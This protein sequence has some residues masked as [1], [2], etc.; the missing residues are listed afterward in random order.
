MVRH[1][2]PST[3]NRTR[4]ADLDSA[5]RRLVCAL[6]LPSNVRGANLSSEIVVASFLRG[7]VWPTWTRAP[8]L[9]WRGFGMSPP[10]V[11]FLSPGLE[12]SPHRHAES[13]TRQRNSRRLQPPPNGTRRRRQDRRR[14]GPRL[15]GG[16]SVTAGTNI[17][18]RAAKV[19]I[20]VASRRSRRGAGFRIGFPCRMDSASRRR[21]GW[22]SWELLRRSANSGLGWRAA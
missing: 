2:C 19:A 15:L 18:S 17:V 6:A 22:C 13:S 9:R 7:G 1:V 11:T 8:S 4:R 5:H 14:R 20:I 10:S 12:S 21:R 3:A 16:A